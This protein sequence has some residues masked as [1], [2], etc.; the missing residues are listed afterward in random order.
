MLVKTIIYFFLLMI[1]MYTASFGVIK[2]AL[3]IGLS[4]IPFLDLEKFS[5]LKSPSR[6]YFLL[7]IW[8]IYFG[9][10]LF[11]GIN[12]GFP[13]PNV[14]LIYNWFLL[15]PV[16]FSIGHLM[17]KIFDLK[18]MHRVLEK[19]T[20]TIL[21][22]S[23]IFICLEFFDLTSSFR[24]IF[25]AKSF[26]ALKIEEGVLSLRQQNQTALVFLLPFNILNFYLKDKSLNNFPYM[27]FFNISF[28]SFISAIGGRRITQYTLVLVF[29]TLCFNFLFNLYKTKI[30]NIKLIKDFLL[31]KKNF[32]LKLIPFGL[33][34]YLIYFILI[35][36]EKLALGNNLIEAYL[37]TL[38]APFDTVGD[39]GT[40][41]RISQIQYLFEGWLR[42]PL[43]GNGLT[44]YVD[45]VVRGGNLTPW[46]Y[47]AFY[48][49]LLFQ[50]GIAGFLVFCSTVYGILFGFKLPLFNKLSKTNQSYFIIPISIIIFF[51]ASATNPFWD[52]VAIWSLLFYSS[53]NFRDL[54]ANKH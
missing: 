10:S 16:S 12:N 44:S 47:E 15:L 51:I 33:I 35:N 23:S 21:I 29:V 49:A 14:R 13:Y 46:S 19:V 48:P 38:L 2:I 11:L 30:I 34:I 36:V 24:F 53:L 39:K 17:Y 6:V 43:F 41:V 31:S 20:F 9:F 54:R 37:S 8:V 7:L 4:I 45:E 42:A 28:G 50:A 32:I 1:F 26:S 25:P 40:I 52:N 22:F 18:D 3:T 5:F 27:C